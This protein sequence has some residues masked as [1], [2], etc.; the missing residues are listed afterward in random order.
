[1]RRFLMFLAVFGVGSVVL[2]HFESKRRDEEAA[3]TEEKT[4]REAGEAPL[5][6]Q[7]DGADPGAG[8]GPGGG[9]ADGVTSSAPVDPQQGVV[10]R[11][12]LEFTSPG[13]GSRPNLTAK[14]A[15][16]QP[17]SARGDRY[18]VR[19]IEIVSKVRAEDGS[20][21][22]N[23]SIHAPRGQ[24]ALELNNNYPTGFARD[25]PVELFDVHLVRHRDAPFVP[26]ELRGPHLRAFPQLERYDSDGD[27]VVEIEGPGLEGEGR[28]L[29]YNGVTQVLRFGRSAWVRFTLEDGREVD[30]RTIGDGPLEIER[31]K[32]DSSRFDVIA[33]GGARLELLGEPPATLNA[34]RIAVS[35]RSLP[36]GRLSLESARAWGT[37]VVT[38]GTDRF[39][40]ESASVQS[41]GGEL[42]RVVLNDSPEARVTVRDENDEALY[43]VVKGS[44]PLVVD[45]VRVE[46]DVLR[47]V[48]VFHGP[49]AMDVDARQ[50]R[51]T[52]EDR[53]E[54]RAREDEGRA[55]FLAAGGVVAIREAVQIETE[56]LTAVIIG[57]SRGERLDTLTV[58]TEGPTVLTG[59]TDD[60]ADLRAD[61]LGGLVA[62]LHEAP[63]LQESRREEPRWLLDRATDVRIV[64][65]G[66]EPFSADAGLVRDGD[67]AARTFR[68]EG[69]VHYASLLGE[70]VATRG[71]V[72]G[73]ERV[74]LQGDQ[75]RPARV[76][77]APDGSLFESPEGAR[78][79]APLGEARAGELSALAITLS[80]SAL[81]ARG[82][83]GGYVATAD[84]RLV[85][86]ADQVRITRLA[87]TEDDSDIEPVTLVADGVRR[88]ELVGAESVFLLAARRV[89][90]DASVA[91]KS[92]AG[93]LVGPAAGA[94]GAAPP[95]ESD[96]ADPAV[97][98]RHLE[99][100]LID[101]NGGASLSMRTTDGSLD[102]D[103]DEVRLLRGSG[104]LPDGQPALVADTFRLTAHRVIQATLER[105]D[106]TL[107]ASCTD[108]D[109][110]GTFDGRAIARVGSVLRAS[111]DVWVKETGANQLESRCDRLELFDGERAVLYAGAGRRIHAEG[112][113][114]TRGPSQAP[115]VYDLFADQITHTSDSLEALTPELVL[116]QA[117]AAFEFLSEFVLT[118]A[119]AGRLRVTPLELYLDGG[120]Q[121]SGRSADGIPIEVDA[122]F[123]RAVPVEP[124]TPPST[125]DDGSGARAKKVAHTFLAQE[126]AAGAAGQE[127]RPSPGDGRQT[128]ARGARP[129]APRFRE[130]ELGQ[131][132]EVRYGAAGQLVVRAESI[133]SD[134]TQI[135]LIGWPNQ[136]AVLEYEGNTIEATWIR[137]DTEEYL[138][139]AGRGIMR[140][141]PGISEWTLAFASIDPR[142]QGEESMIVVASP[143]LT[144]GRDEMRADWM[145]IWL[146]RDA[147]RAKGASVLYS[148]AEPPPPPPPAF[149]EREI[150][151]PDLL[152][153]ALLNLQQKEFAAYV[154]AMYAEGDIEVSQGGSRTSRADALF[155]DVGQ[156]SGWLSGAELVQRVEA[157]SRSELIRIRAGR[158]ETDGSGRLIA[159]R[160]TLTT[161]D[162]DEPHYVVLTQELALEPRNDGR[163]RFGAR[164][165]R[166]RFA[167]G[168]QVPLPSIGN[169]VLD[170]RGGFEGFENDKGEVAPLN[171]L[172]I[173]QTA[174]F[175]AA[176]G[177]SFGFETGKIGRWLASLFGM[178]TDRLRGRWDTS[179]QWLGDRGP[180]VSVELDLRERKPRDDLG[181]D[182]R[183]TYYVAGI[184]DR[185]NDRGVNRVSEDEREEERVFGWVRGRYPIVR[186]EWIDFAFA[187]QT[188]AG[189]Q[190]EF[191][192][193]DYLEFDQR[194][195]F[196]RWRKARDGVYLSAGV[197]KRVDSFRTDVE[198][199][200][201]FGAYVGQRE[202]ATLGAASLLYGGTADVA[203]LRRREGDPTR[204]PFSEVP[205]GAGLGL[206]GRSTVRGR[207][208]QRL[209]LSTPTGVAGVRTTPFI[210]LDATGWSEDQLEEED[211][212]RVALLTGLELSTA[213]HSTAGGFTNVLAPRIGARTDLVY[214]EQGG[215]PTP[216]DRIERPIDGTQYEA[217]LRGLWARP[218]TF[219]NLDV[220]LRL[221][222][223][224][225]RIDFEDTTEVGVLTEWITRV[226]GDANGRVG[227]RHDGRYDVEDSE[228]NYSRSTLAWSP[229]ADF[230]IEG[231]YGRARG[232]DGAGLYE[233]AGV[234]ARWTLD[235]KW[236]LEVRQ[237]WSLSGGGNLNS[238]VSVRRFAHDFMLEFDISRRAGEGGTSFGISFNPLLAWKRPRLG[239]LDRR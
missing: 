135:S 64:V 210:E 239:L 227:I 109:V 202:I 136:P 224:E 173:A 27:D 142:I 68:A 12:A 53:M 211:A 78:L 157:G 21:V 128:G 42:S 188:D 51:V 197:T 141:A 47:A 146:L 176:I 59:P 3:R 163:W 19:G 184:P 38:R 183:M 232:A 121:A 34:E 191:F 49:G 177:A 40:G 46:P 102:I 168:L 107:R 223:T 133:S 54:G 220:D 119:R 175:G 229:S 130:L 134:G 222:R 190:A 192:E 110:R 194:D 13:E 218:G 153:E 71:L 149:A 87:P 165:N 187:G 94:A 235:N 31:D 179:A 195:T 89:Q 1:M 18:E 144:R 97:R 37:V 114:P 63:S 96:T 29:E 169:A 200:P 55:E 25:E 207:L 43:I 199:L 104:T 122:G 95:G 226:G 212:S 147:W 16:L 81:D 9:A 145:S 100:H 115:L 234:D 129:R 208:A 35:L 36:S 77:L 24:L 60:G 15:D 75:G 137:F 39:T 33:S 185:G 32:D 28:A 152:A 164:G 123:L 11:G 56:S 209:D 203:H 14:F 50:L 93:P 2:W 127:N 162:H 230:L 237:T 66:A 90:V 103:A 120:V 44:G 98:P 10:L 214:E 233:A 174:R 74:E 154:R 65:G 215:T 80:E 216:F 167:N 205:S 238:G 61:A 79:L 101:A 131:G 45:I 117:G 113:L 5:F 236:E 84:G 69:E 156:A 105:P 62:R 204:D 58:L 76:V 52:F 228:T 48:F 67:L 221:L 125:L 171:S 23:E 213:L 126:P 41:P 140:S 112:V 70:A 170:E 206:D 20:L 189:V 196:V 138:V 143:R 8:K 99:L 148:D 186:G 193:G 22:L 85:L 178:D 30:F 26:L 231:R 82:A 132:V 106:R 225:D 72:R 166:L 7:G 182:F 111:G 180:L 159:N 217:G 86:D 150:P 91:A 172:T 158:L 155:L 116:E 201:S 57:D 88:A 160:A 181:E 83:V 4:K 198:E 151:G 92:A 6:P 73:R 108:L 17:G 139:S 161:C 219:E 118:S 124:L